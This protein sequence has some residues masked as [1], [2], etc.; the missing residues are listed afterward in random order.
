VPGRR[1][2]RPRTAVSG[3][4]VL[5]VLM[6]GVTVAACSPSP[7]RTS[8]TSRPAP[9]PSITVGAPDTTEQLIVASLYADV[10]RRAG[11]TVTLR[12]GLGTRA[13]VEPALASGQL[14]LYPDEAGSLLLYL[15]SN[16]TAA[17][18]RTATALPELRRIL[19][20]ARATVL[21]P[22]PALDTEVFVVTRAT[23]TQDHLTTLS[24]LAPVASKLVLGGP[25]T[26]PTDPQCEP[27][28]HSTYG[29][30]FK[31]FTSLDDAGPITVAALQGGEI[32]VG[33][34]NASDGTVLADHFVAL[35]D[36][37]H[38]LNADNVVP[39]IRTSVDTRLVAAALD[40][41]SAELTTHQLAQLNLE[42]T[43]DH[44]SPATVARRWLVH[45]HL[46]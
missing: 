7:P 15:D 20:V 5:G 34:L 30:H 35:T 42:V 18:T 6:M 45:V 4:L 44:D 33:E 43:A 11:A 32:Q 40:G 36:D 3:A 28:L 46:I 10:L 29:L 12:T 19:G 13:S 25:P 26:C 16:D 23:A 22:A 21:R 27:G 1:T 39:V 9:G 24:S 17:A 8:A 2:T 38:L 31:S 41:L 37:G 14:D